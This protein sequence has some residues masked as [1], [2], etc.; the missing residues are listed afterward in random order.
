MHRTVCVSQLLRGHYGHTRALAVAPSRPYHTREHASRGVAIYVT[1][2][3]VI[4]VV[5]EATQTHPAL[6]HV[7]LCLC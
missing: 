2:V 4:D 1:F 6:L 5:S 7:R 3:S